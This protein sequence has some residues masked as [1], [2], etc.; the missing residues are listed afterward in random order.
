MGYSDMNEYKVYCLETLN[1]RNHFLNTVIIKD[2][3]NKQPVL[4]NVLMYSG[5]IH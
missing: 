4:S 2:Y 5:T 3:I 1:R